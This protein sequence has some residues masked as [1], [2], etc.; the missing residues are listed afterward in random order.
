MLNDIFNGGLLVRRGQGFWFKY[1]FRGSEN[2]IRRGQ[3]LD[4]PPVLVD[5]YLRKVMGERE[6]EKAIERDYEL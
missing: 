1:V 2:D 5:V 4:S 6:R 3:K